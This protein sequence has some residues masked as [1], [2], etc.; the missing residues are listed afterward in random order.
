VRPGTATAIATGAMLPRGADAVVMVEHT[1]V[2]GGELLL[3]RP[4][5]PGANVSFTGT[6]VG[7]GEV[8]LRRGERLSSRETG[9]FAALG[10][11]EVA[12]VGRPRVAIL[13]TGDELLPPGTPIRPGFVHDSNSTVLADAV[14]ELGGE[15]VPLGI[16]PDDDSKLDNALAGALAC[17][18][19][20]L[21]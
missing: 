11:A 10:I 18:A 8:V 6:D 21:S 20:L 14:R 3:M 4:V 16:V 2:E 1:D 17:D 12:V 7:T 5:A 13:S 19:I 9:V 15:A